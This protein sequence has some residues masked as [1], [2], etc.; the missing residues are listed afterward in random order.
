MKKAFV[1]LIW[2]ILTILGFD[3]AF[4][5]I[6][7]AS[8]IAGIAGIFLVFFIIVITIKTMFFTKFIKK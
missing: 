4:S 8:T 5:W 1:I 3:L 2:A 7:M 6:N